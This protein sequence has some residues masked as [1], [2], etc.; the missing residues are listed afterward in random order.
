MCCCELLSV[1]NDRALG[2]TRERQCRSW[3]PAQTRSPSD[4]AGFQ[5]SAGRSAV[6]L[7][8]WKGTEFRGIQLH[9][10]PMGLSLTLRV[11]VRGRR[12]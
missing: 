10:W 9:Q 3:V 1:A 7:G 8:L 12:R 11:S 4:P 6:P 5:C 2:L